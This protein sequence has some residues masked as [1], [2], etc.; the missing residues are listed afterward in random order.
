MTRWPRN[1]GDEFL[2]LS[3]TEIEAE[4]QPLQPQLVNSFN[5][6]RRPRPPGDRFLAITMIVIGTAMMI[7]GI[8]LLGIEY[9]P[10]FPHSP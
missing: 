3:M 9:W 10:N 1:L 4:R 6:R 2:D 7:G 8:L 5:L